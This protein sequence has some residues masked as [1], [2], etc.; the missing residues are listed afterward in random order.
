[1][2]W[3]D[4]C[5]QLFNLGS[6]DPPPELIVQDEF[7]LISGPLGTLAGL[8]ETAV[9]LL[10]R[11]EG[12]TPKVIASTATIRRATGQTRA[13]FD[14]QMVPVPSPRLDA[15]DSYFAVEA[16]P[17]QAR[18]R[19]YVGLARA[20]R[21]PRDA[22]D[23]DVRRLL[24]SA[25]DLEAATEVRDAYWTLLGYF[26]SL[27]V[28]GGAR[29]QVQDDVVDRLSLIARGGHPRRTDDGVIEM[30]SRIESGDIPKHLAMME[31][32]AARCDR[33]CPRHEH[34]LGRCRYR[35][36]RTDGRDGTATVHLGIHPGH[37]PRRQATP[38]ARDRAL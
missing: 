12:A 33:R 5:R 16:P 37:Q 38:W 2:P 36:T 35:P 13:L 1:M 7:H 24:Q 32:P 29:M 4:Q 22:D 31:R 25:Q 23:S 11:H 8:Y 19:L 14:R 27:R 26:N 17:G 34:D 9:D 10:C 21:K 18:D 28:F 6:A 3:R 30:T 20:H 15:R